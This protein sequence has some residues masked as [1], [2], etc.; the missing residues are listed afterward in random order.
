MV[1][2]A[3]NL[4]LL[5]KLMVNS[6]VSGREI[7]GQWRRAIPTGVEQIKVLSFAFLTITLQK[8]FSTCFD[9]G[10]GFRSCSELALSVYFSVWGMAI[11][12]SYQLPVIAHM[13]GGLYPQ[14]AY[15]L[16][17]MVRHFARKDKNCCVSTYRSPNRQWA[18]F[19]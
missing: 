3:W 14:P 12:M 18:N 6:F 16:F 1:P 15:F 17:C 4:F 2:S 8:I 7:R 13:Y 11:S 10:L 9:G 5:S 19:V